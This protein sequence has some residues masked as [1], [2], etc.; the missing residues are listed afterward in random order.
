MKR[1]A[2][3]QT[4]TALCAAA[5]LMTVPATAGAGQVTDGLAKTVD[6]L[7]AT[8]QD[9]ALKAAAKQQCRSRLLRQQSA[10][11]FD[12]AQ[13]ARRTLGYHWREITDAQRARFI[14][15]FTDFLEN[16]YL[17]RID[18]FLEQTG[19]FSS[20]NISYTSERIDGRYALVETLIEVKGQQYPMNYKLRQ[21]AQGWKVYD[22]P[23]GGGGLVA[24]YRTPFSDL[25]S[26][27]S[28]DT[29]LERLQQRT[30]PEIGKATQES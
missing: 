25:L 18:S 23:L 22:I 1:Y 20:K 11:S 28:F 21:T 13:M 7:I 27:A 14:E 3:R 9:P 16:T 26:S 15:L 4:L 12:W 17:H 6:Q 30:L 10:T 19:D 29:L 5:L 8:L 2:M 24:T